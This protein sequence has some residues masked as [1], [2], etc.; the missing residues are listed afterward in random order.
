MYK[1]G[2]INIGIEAATPMADGKPGDISQF[3]DRVANA[4]D[5]VERELEQLADSISCALTQPEPRPEKSP[6]AVTS[7]SM[8]VLGQALC[9]INARLLAV[10]DRMQDLRQRVQL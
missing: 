6:N 7:G 8:S 5:M 2:R 10:A 1:E 9:G 3:Y 4:V